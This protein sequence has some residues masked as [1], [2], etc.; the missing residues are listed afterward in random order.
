MMEGGAGHRHHVEMKETALKLRTQ[1][2]E[3]RITLNAGT[4]F[5]I[6]LF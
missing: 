4:I 5:R 6:F 1:G 2:K 3:V